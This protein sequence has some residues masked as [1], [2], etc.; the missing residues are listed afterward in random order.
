MVNCGATERLTELLSAVDGRQTEPTTDIRS[1]GWNGRDRSLHCIRLVPGPESAT[2]SVFWLK[3]VIKYTMFKQILWIF[4]F[5]LVL[6]SCSTEEAVEQVREVLDN[7]QRRE[8]MV[9]E[10][11][12]IAKR[13]YSYKVLNQKLKYLVSDCI[14]CSP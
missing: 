6:T 8:A 10:N 12:E 13:F 3:P 11:Y 7:P 5:F 14:A 4:L 9:A 1:T 2:L